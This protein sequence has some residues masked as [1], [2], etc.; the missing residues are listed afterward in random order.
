MC[1][2]YT[3]T[4]PEEILRKLFDFGELPDLGPPRYNIAP[5]QPVVGVTAGKPGGRDLQLRLFRWGLVPFWAKD[6]D[7]GNRLINARSETAS[8]K[9]AFRAAMK[10]RR[11]L[12]PADGFYEWKKTDEGKQ[13]YHIGMEGHE[14]FALAG[15][16]ESWDGGGTGP[17]ETCAI[18]TTEPNELLAEVH[19]RMPVIIPP[20][21]FA[22][23]L[24]PDATDPGELASLLG[25]YPPGEMTA[26][27][28]SRRVNR[29][30]HDAPE[31]IEPIEQG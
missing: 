25:P 11:C 1:G 5:S 16:W 23:W 15:L 18:L 9:P 10:Y 22:R 14:P 4:S 13:P 8:T 31:C 19:N 2:R 26:Y 28:V 29:P 27:P 21:H 12:L 3:L 17:L 6:P 24:D 30:T 20:E 7:I